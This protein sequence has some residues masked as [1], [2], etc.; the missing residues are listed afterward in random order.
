MCMVTIFLLRIVNAISISGDSTISAMSII[1]LAAAS[2][3]RIYHST[4]IRSA[5]ARSS[6]PVAKR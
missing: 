5:T 6:G 4:H 1:H 3:P 2:Y